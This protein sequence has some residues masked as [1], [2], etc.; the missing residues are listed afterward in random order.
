MNVIPWLQIKVQVAKSASLS[1]ATGWIGNPVFAKASELPGHV[2]SDRVV[3]EVLLNQAEDLV[4]IIAGQ[5]VKAAG[6]C[7]GLD[8]YHGVILPLSG[9]SC[10]E[11]EM[12]DDLRMQ[13]SG[14]LHRSPE[15]GPRR[16]VRL[17]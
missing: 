6:E 5:L 7:P 12:G 13:E 1:F 17:R 8:E 2:P 10:Q 9:M 16:I 4:S 15:T 14:G 3:E 11:A